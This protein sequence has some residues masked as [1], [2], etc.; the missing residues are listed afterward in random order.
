MTAAE[1]LILFRRELFLKMFRASP[2]G[3]SKPHINIFVPLS[4][5]VLLLDSLFVAERGGTIVLF[6]FVEE[7]ARNRYDF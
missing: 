1:D 5:S 4:S 2:M 3:P 7:F 6:A